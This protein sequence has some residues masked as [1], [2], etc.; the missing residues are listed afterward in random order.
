MLSFH[1]MEGCGNDFVV[2]RATPASPEISLEQVQQLCDRRRGIGADGVLVI[3]ETDRSAQGLTAAVTIW[4]SDGSRPETCGNGLRCVA[5]RLLEDGDWDG[6]APLTL[7]PPAG[8]AQV[9]QV[10]LPDQDEPWLEVTMGR[11]YVRGDLD[12][13]I[14]AGK[15]SV[16]GHRVSMGNPHFVVFEAQQPAP[17][18]QL[19]EWAPVISTSKHFP[20]GTNVEWVHLTGEAQ[21]TIRVWERGVGETPA[22]GSGACA[23]AAAART[24]GLCTADSIDVILPGGALRVSWDGQAESPTSLAGPARTVFH[25]TWTEKR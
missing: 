17:L 1:K 6:S 25:G 19:R 18:P 21:L 8:S 13:P 20:D 2:V 11:P 22:C 3:G 5:R 4:N 23:A 14:A 9:R 7:T 15:Q 12:E 10:S 24:Q 16:R